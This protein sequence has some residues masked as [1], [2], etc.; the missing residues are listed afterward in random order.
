MVSEADGYIP[1]DLASRSGSDFEGYS[2]LFSWSY[3]SVSAEVPLSSLSDI[4]LFHLPMT[5][6]CINSWL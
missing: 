5:S 2:D 1:A 6:Y 4:L 3:D